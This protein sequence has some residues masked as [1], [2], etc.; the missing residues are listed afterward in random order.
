MSLDG[1][2]AEEGYGANKSERCKSLHILT[3][4]HQL[5]KR[6]RKVYTAP[7]HKL[8][9][10]EGEED[11]ILLGHPWIFDNEIGRLP[12]DC[13]DGSPVDVLTKSGHFLGRG[14]IN[15]SSRITVR[16]FTRNKDEQINRAFFAS[17]IRAAA[18]TRSFFYGEGDSYRLLFAESDLLP[19]LVVE[20]FV[21]LEGRVFLVVQF[22]T[23]AVDSFRDDIVAAL[24]EVIRP[25]GIF[26]RSD[27]HVRALEG[28]SERKGWIGAEFDP[29]IVIRENGIELT[30]DLENGQ[31]TGYF[32]DQKDNR[33]LAARISK[34]REVLDTCS[35]TGAFG[36]NAWKGGASSVLAIDIS[37]DAV[38]GIRGNIARNGAEA[39]MRAETH[40]V[41]DFLKAQ[42]K[43]GKKYDFIILDPPAFTKSAKMIDKAYGGYKE[44]N[45]RAMKI[46]RPGGFLMTC[47]CSHF[48]TSDHFYRM[49]QNAARDAHR[50]V[51]VLEKRGP[52]PDHPALSGYP[53]SD[54]L[55]CALCRVW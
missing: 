22:L 25:A 37:E 9:L 50:T 7:M 54:Y 18:E 29:R 38:A 46:L 17:R 6:Q 12:A 47:S 32:L 55:K 39:A 2:D 33:A 44:I 27:V 43:D 48:F 16:L 8:F 5:A 34:G 10:K 52:G 24:E 40:D 53:E 13:P 4:T 36:L 51:Q 11:R 20:R 35:H 1:T 15:R 42:E 41:F 31:K 23:L 28:L 49:I 30:V 3:I 26:E 21:D 14:V 19:G 45:L